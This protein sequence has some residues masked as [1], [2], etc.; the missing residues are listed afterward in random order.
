MIIR[1]GSS[2]LVPVREKE[3]DVTPQAVYESRR[4]W[5]AWMATGA[6]GVAMALSLIHI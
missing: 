5:L 2:P 6:A 1:P 4:Q 3:A